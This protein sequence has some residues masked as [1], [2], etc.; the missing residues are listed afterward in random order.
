MTDNIFETPAT[1]K[2]DDLMGDGKKYS[3]Q[4]AVAKALV[5]KDTFI[6]RLIDEKRQLE[7]TF[8]ERENARAFDDRIK[9][10]EQAQLTERT[11]PPAREVTPPQPS[12]DPAKIEE[13]VQRSI[14]EREAQNIRSRNL[15]TVKDTLTEKIGE[16]YTKYVKQRAAELNIG[17][18]QLNQMAA[19]TPQAF[20]ALV[21]P[22][23]RTPE[24][25]APPASR[26]NPAAFTPQTNSRGNKYYSEM[27]KSDPTR[28]FTPAVQMEEFQE[29]KRQGPERFYSS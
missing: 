16:D 22:S 1:M 8:R 9:A 5:E 23:D 21:L 13:M 18:D 10:L 25:V 27:R 24:S 29:L 17:M 12:V 4:D 2:L 11:E 15:I 19:N 28:Y 26:V 3:D 20:L 14:A 7:E 6:Q